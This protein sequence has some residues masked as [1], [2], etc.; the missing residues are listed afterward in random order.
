MGGKKT[1]GVSDGCWEKTHCFWEGKL[2]KNNILGRRPV[3]KNLSTLRWKKEQH[4]FCIIIWCG[5]WV[6]PFQ[7]TSR[8]WNIEGPD[9]A[10]WKTISPIF[11][12]PRASTW[13]RKKCRLQVNLFTPWKFNIAPENKSSPKQSNLPSIVF[14][15]RAVKL[16]GCICWRWF[17]H[18][19]L[20]IP[21]LEVTFPTSKRVTFPSQKGHL[22]QNWQVQTNGWR[23]SCSTVL[24]AS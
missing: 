11:R 15:E 3:S 12:K 10:P 13:N 22:S 7:K 18:R 1:V 19:D 4:R 17:S 5:F 16:W 14:Q 24:W 6:G 2:W 8:N 9:H 21:W 23:Y 20:F